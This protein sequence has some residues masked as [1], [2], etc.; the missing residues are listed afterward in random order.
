MVIGLVLQR[1]RLQARLAIGDVVHDGHAVAL[2]GGLRLP[3]IH[4]GAHARHLEWEVLAVAHLVP[5]PHA[6]LQDGQPLGAERHEVQEVALLVAR[7]ELLRDVRLE[8]TPHAAQRRHQGV[9][10]EHS[11]TAGGAQQHTG[12]GRLHQIL[13][14]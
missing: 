7:A 14:A 10:E 11:P 8:D 4:L 6:V 1:R 3:H 12:E 2:Q 5:A 9:A 13:L